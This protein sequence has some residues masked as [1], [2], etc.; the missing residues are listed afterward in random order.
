MLGEAGRAN[1]YHVISRVVNREMAFG[2]VEKEGEISSDLGE[3]VG[4]LMR[5]IL[6]VCFAI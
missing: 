6:R 3:A 1:G 5:C 2:D 4:V